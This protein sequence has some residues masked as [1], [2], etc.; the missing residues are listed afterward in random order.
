MRPSLP[1]GVK[2]R[3]GFMRAR[4]PEN[5]PLALRNNA[6]RGHGL[7]VLS[8]RC[9]TARSSS[10]RLLVAQALLDDC[11]QGVEEGAP[12]MFEPGDARFAER[13][14]AVWLEYRWYVQDRG[15]VEVF[16]KWRRV[17]PS[18][19]AREEVSVLRLHLL[20]HCLLYTSDAADE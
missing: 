4:R 2:I 10:M 12:R 20:G 17:E 1:P 3:S 18:A 8:T 15:L 11:F 5:N 19:C 7:S 9:Q 14:S 6:R 16:V 13:T